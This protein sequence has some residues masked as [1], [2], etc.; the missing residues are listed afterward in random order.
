MSEAQ[1]FMVDFTLPAQMTDE[2]ERLIPQQRAEVVSMFSREELVSY[3]LSLETGRLWVIVNATNEVEVMKLLSQLPLTRYMRHTE[4]SP[5]TFH[6]SSM[7]VVP[8][9]SLN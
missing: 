9:F 4:I 6:N 5:L 3:S 2:F 7:R 1:Q 8:T